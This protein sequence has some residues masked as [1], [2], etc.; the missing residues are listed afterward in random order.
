MGEIGLGSQMSY[1]MFFIVVIVSMDKSLE[2]KRALCIFFY[3]TS[4]EP[5][6]YKADASQDYV[7]PHPYVETSDRI[8]LSDEVRSPSPDRW[9]SLQ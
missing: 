7:H 9:S 2:G 4:R 1:M 3:F 6:R 5:Y 8:S